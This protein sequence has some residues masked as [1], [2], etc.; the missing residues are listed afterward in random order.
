[1]LYPSYDIVLLAANKSET[2]ID[3]GRILVFNTAMCVSF[4]LSGTVI[5][6]FFSLLHRTHQTPR[7]V[8]QLSKVILAPHK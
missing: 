7:I 3:P 6:S 8:A 4:V 2:T 1:M 5:K